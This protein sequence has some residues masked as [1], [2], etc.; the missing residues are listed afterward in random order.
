MQVD[1]RERDGGWYDNNNLGTVWFRRRRGQDPGIFGGPRN[2][3]HYELI[4][5][6]TQID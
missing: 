3:Y 2:Y 6:G 4:Y 5:R 1:L